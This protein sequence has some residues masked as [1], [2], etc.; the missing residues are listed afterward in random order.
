MCVCC[1][2]RFTRG[3]WHTLTVLMAAF[4]RLPLTL[5]IWVSWLLNVLTQM[6]RTAAEWFRGK[7]IHTGRGLVGKATSSKHFT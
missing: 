6:P 3:F 4:G 7:K 1:L 2:F 5:P